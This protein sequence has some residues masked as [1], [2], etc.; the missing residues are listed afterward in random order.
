MSSFGPSDLPPPR[1][2]PLPPIK[3]SAASTP[4][5]ARS[6]SHV[7]EL[8]GTSTERSTPPPRRP[9]RLPAV[10][11]AVIA[12]LLVTIIVLLTTG[13]GSRSDDVSASPAT[14]A[15]AAS[16][17]PPPVLPAAATPSPEAAVTDTAEAKQATQAA[18]EE[19]VDEYLR[20]SGASDPDRFVQL[21]AYPADHY[22]EPL[23]AAGMRAATV[24]YFT[25]YP[26]RS[27]RR[28]G[29]VSLTPDPAGVVAAFDYE[30]DLTRADGQA[31]CGV[32][33]LTLR[34]VGDTDLRVAAANETKVSDCS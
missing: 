18:A 10:A 3:G 15:P 33:R 23:D 17:D 8:G 25:S 12:A 16:T 22:G 5:P 2:G 1:P 6:S 11:F 26:S 20:V 21:W 13:R 4:P 27:F 31:R 32:R 14:L 24:A 30:F 29:P 9:S 28:A 19:I 7:L 34:L